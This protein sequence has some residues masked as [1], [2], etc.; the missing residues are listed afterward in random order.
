M[1][2]VNIVH[3]AEGG[4]VLDYEEPFE[5]CSEF[6]NVWGGL[7]DSSPFP[8][9]L[10]FLFHVLITFILM[11]NVVFFSGHHL[12]V[13]DTYQYHSFSFLPVLVL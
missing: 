9:A 12:F 8:P 3:I 13:E 7:A 2:L 4:V 1:L 5:V 10:T 6:G 11:S